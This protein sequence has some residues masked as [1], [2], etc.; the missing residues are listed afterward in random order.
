MD[1]VPTES[2][3]VHLCGHDGHMAVL[4]G[5]AEEVGEGALLMVAELSRLRV[6]FDYAFALHNKPNKELNKI[7][8]YK[9]CLVNLH[10]NI[11]KVYLMKKKINFTQ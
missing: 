4:I 3:P 8:M 9:N 7:L 1:A 10:I 2:G 11:F 5:L 6:N